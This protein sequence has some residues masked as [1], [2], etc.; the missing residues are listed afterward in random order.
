MRN[1]YIYI[2]FISGEPYPFSAAHYLSHPVYQVNEFI[3]VGK[4]LKKPWEIKSTAAYIPPQQ[5][6][7]SNLI[8]QYSGG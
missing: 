6:K 1:S 7:K 2:Y 3:R 5:K 8:K 4:Y